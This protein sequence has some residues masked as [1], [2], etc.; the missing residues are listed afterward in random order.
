MFRPFL[1]FSHDTS[2]EAQVIGTRWHPCQSL[3]GICLSRRKHKI[4][5]PFI[6]ILNPF[7]F[8]LSNK[9]QEKLNKNPNFFIFCRQKKEKLSYYCVVVLFFSFWPVMRSFTT[10]AWMMKERDEDEEGTGKKK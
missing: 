2:I 3:V 7:L 4:D 6:M 1:L 5:A 10:S 8:P 9:E